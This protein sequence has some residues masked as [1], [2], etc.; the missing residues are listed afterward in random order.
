MSQ[1][2]GGVWAERDPEVSKVLALVQ[3]KGIPVHVIDGPER[4]PRVR[5]KSEP[6][7]PRREGMLP[8]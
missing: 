2:L 4:K 6:E 3:R 7:P 8:D 1:G 5:R